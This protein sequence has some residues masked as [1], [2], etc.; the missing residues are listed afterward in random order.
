MKDAATTPAQPKGSA[1]LIFW[2]VGIVALVWNGLGC[3]NFVMQLSPAGIA[4]LPPDYQAFIE[5][6][7]LWALIAFAVSVVAGFLGA[8]LLLLRSRQSIPAFVASCLGALVSVISI[9]ELDVMSFVIGSVMS[10][11]LVAFFAWYSSRTLV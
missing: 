11:V 7:P 9:L 10:V 4:T 6:R 5:V 8:V 1:R 3:V 2:L